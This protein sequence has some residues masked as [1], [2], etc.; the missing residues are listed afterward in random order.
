[1]AQTLLIPNPVILPPLLKSMSMVSK[2]IPHDELAEKD[3]TQA[4]FIYGCLHDLTSF[5]SG[6][7]C[8]TALLRGNSE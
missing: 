6:K 7:M 4:W 8:I 5:G 3:K 2:G 1:M